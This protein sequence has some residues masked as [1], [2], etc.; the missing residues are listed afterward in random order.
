MPWSESLFSWIVYSALASLAVLGIGS[1]AALLC[2][3]PARR[4]RIIELSLAGCLIVPWLGMIPGYPRLAIAWLY[5][6]RDCP[7]LHAGENGTVP[8]AAPFGEKTP[9]TEKHFIENISPSPSEA[10]GAASGTGP[11]FAEKTPFA[12]NRLA[13]NMDLSPSRPRLP[14]SHRN[15]L[16]NRLPKLLSP[17]RRLT[18]LGMSLFGS[19]LF[20]CPA[21][22]WG[23][24]GGWWA[25]PPLLRILWTAHPA[26]PRYRRLLLQIAGWHG[27]RVRLLTSRLARQPFA[28]PWFFGAAVKRSVGVA[29]ELPPQRAAWWPATIVLPKNLGDDEQAVRWALAHEWTHIERHDFPAWLAAD[30][31]RVLFFYQPL[32]WWLRR[33]LRLCQD[34][35]ADAG[36]SRQAPQPEDYAEF[37]TLRAAAG[38]LHPAM[39]G[40]GMGFRKSELYRR[41]VMLVQ[42]PPLESRVPRL[43]T[44]SVTCAALILVAVVAALSAS[45][46]ASAQGE[47][48][49]QSE[50]S[51]PAAP[52]GDSVAPVKADAS[53]PLKVQLPEGVTIELLGVGHDRFGWWKPDG[54]PLDSKEGPFSNWGSA[55]SVPAGQF[56]RAFVLRVQAPMNQNISPLARS[57]LVEG[58]NISEPLLTEDGMPGQSAHMDA[59][60]TFAGNMETING[61]L[62]GS[63]PEKTAVTKVVLGLTFAWKTI[64][65]R[66]PLGRVIGEKTG[67]AVVAPN[68]TLPD[69]VLNVLQ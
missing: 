63:F 27:D 46:Q 17:M 68:P 35:V 55:W 33:Q 39:V 4:L 43:W 21:W 25:W 54:S 7:N 34:F 38:S 69:Q 42:N 58:V 10:P 2:R 50:P 48:A 61:K 11:F 9:F 20:I 22:R 8:F 53:Q 28:V 66:D 60:Y 67:E 6:S 44:L 51:E 19:S 15:R 64:G 40:L 45:P 23:S 1:V 13:E 14:T 41:I 52:F 56:H 49:A 57:A 65:E 37:L 36:A 30:L 47:P 12:D 24:F 16:P 62:H 5:I 3:Q 26:T 59:N 32:V 18:R 29:V 31:V